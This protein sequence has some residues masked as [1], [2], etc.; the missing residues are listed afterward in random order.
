MLSRN[1]NDHPLHGAVQTLWEA[2]RT[3]SEGVSFQGK[4]DMSAMWVA[5]LAGWDASQIAIAKKKQA[6]NA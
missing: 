2:W 3:S 4:V 6:D 5:F 1:S